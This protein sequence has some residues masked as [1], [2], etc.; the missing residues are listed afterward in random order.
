MGKY[1]FGVLLFIFSFLIIPV[2]NSPGVIAKQSNS[3]NY[4]LD[5]RI[6]RVLI[7][8]EWWIIEYS[9]NGVIMNIYKESD[10]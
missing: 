3:T 7:D 8:G 5:N 6:E 1:F 4:F 2:S 10:D 9:D